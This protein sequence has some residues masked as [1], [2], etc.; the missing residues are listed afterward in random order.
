MFFGVYGLTIEIHEKKK[1]T[2]CPE[3]FLFLMATFI[4]IQ[5][6]IMLTEH[7]YLSKFI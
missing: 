1:K 2:F 6:V 4:V 3:T 5:V 7:V